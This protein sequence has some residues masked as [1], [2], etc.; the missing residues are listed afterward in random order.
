ML[1][2]NRFKKEYDKALMKLN[3]LESLFKAREKMI[4]SANRIVQGLKLV[5]KE[6][7]EACQVSSSYT[8]SVFACSFFIQQKLTRRLSDMLFYILFLLLVRRLLFKISSAL[9]RCEFILSIFRW[10]L[11]K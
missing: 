9:T 3:E 2:A 7:Q 1:P 4:K 5:V 6:R 11:T 8:S 10:A